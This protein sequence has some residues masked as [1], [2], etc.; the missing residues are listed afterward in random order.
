MPDT[1]VAVV[2]PCASGKSTIVEGLRDLG[3]DAFSV[4]QEHS[5]IGDL[6]RHRD[7][8]LLVYLDVSLNTIRARRS[9]PDWPGW[10]YDHQLERLERAR[11]NA[12]FIID[13]NAKSPAE[14]VAEL[15]GAIGQTGMGECSGR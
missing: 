12:S 1:T 15:S 7:P 9:N 6:W 4:A 3:I 10:I 11:A 13:T 8:D 2:G 5:I 14:I